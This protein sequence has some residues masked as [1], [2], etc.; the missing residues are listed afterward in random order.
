[1]VQHDPSRESRFFEPLQRPAVLVLHDDG[2]WYPGRL[3]AWLPVLPR[4]AWRAVV[5]YEVGRMGGDQFYR[6]V[7]SDQVREAP[8]PRLP[9]GEP[10][11]SRP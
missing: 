6:V 4:P 3:R 9:L 1:M 11:E 8:G 7:P 2:Q 5:S 10:V